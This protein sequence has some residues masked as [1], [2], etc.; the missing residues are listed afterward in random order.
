MEG[1][2]KWQRPRTERQRDAEREVLDLLEEG[3][4]R[5]RERDDVILSVF[6]RGGSIAC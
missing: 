6:S 1:G 4:H 3:G 5:E 2:E